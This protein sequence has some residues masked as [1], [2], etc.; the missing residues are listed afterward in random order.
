MV[1]I[2]LVAAAALSLLSVGCATTTTSATSAHVGRPE[3]SETDIEAAVQEAERS[4]LARMTNSVDPETA[5]TA[6]QLSLAEG[7]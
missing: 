3:V 1:V 6:R 5:Q 7:R 2:Q 4:A